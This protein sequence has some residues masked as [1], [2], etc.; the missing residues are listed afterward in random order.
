[1]HLSGRKSIH[2]T[3]LLLKL[4]D[5]GTAIMLKKKGNAMVFLN[6]WLYQ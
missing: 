3:F 5:I 1:M 4:N 6:S 2:L